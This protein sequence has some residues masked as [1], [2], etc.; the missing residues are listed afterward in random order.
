MHKTHTGDD[1]FLLLHPWILVLVS[2]LFSLP[3][4]FLSL[5]SLAPNFLPQIVFTVAA[6]HLMNKRCLSSIPSLVLHVLTLT[7]WAPYLLNQTSSLTFAL[8]LCLALSFLI[9]PIQILPGLTHGVFIVN[10]FIDLSPKS[11]LSISVSF[12]F[13][14]TREVR[15]SPRRE[16]KGRAS[17]F[18]R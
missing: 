3:L 1:T 7:P 4:L 10:Y 15:S 6:R 14:F 8:S 12:L 17:T 11:L 2:S 13:W 18:Q 16:R 5:F 9:T